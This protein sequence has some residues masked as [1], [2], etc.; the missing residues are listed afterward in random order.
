MEDKGNLTDKAKK[1]GMFLLKK[2]Q[3]QIIYLTN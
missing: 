3:T 2:N 1:K